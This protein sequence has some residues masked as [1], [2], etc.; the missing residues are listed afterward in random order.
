MKRKLNS[1]LIAAACSLFMFATSQPAVGDP[2]RIIGYDIQN[3]TLPGYG[4]WSHYY[5]GTITPTDEFRANYSGGTG[6]LANDI[7]ESIE[8]QIQLFRTSV[9]PVTTLYLDAFYTINTIDIFGGNT[10]CNYIPGQIEW[11]NV[12]INSLTQ[13]LFGGAFGENNAGGTPRND[14]FTISGS[15]LEGLVT[16]RI[17]LSSVFENG[18]CQAFSIAEIQVGGNLA[19]APVPEPATLGLIGFSVA[20]MAWRR[21]RQT[22]ANGNSTAR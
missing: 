20:I 21:R 9:Q 12:T 13:T 4:G 5:L 15:S 7:V 17:V 8:Q 19:E 10:C 1:W 11:L 14:R 18:C 2:V 22:I 16:D 3:A 6:T